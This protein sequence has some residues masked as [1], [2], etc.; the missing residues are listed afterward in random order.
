MIRCP[1][2]RTE[3]G[4]N[5]FNVATDRAFCRLCNADYRYGELATTVWP[6]KQF[7]VDARPTHVQLVDDGFQ[8]TLVYH[9]ISRLIF[10]FIPFTALWSGL[11][12][13]GLYVYPWLAGKPI[14]REQALFGIPFVIGTIVLLAAML[15][16][17][18]GKTT[19]RLQ[20]PESWVLTGIGPIGR[21][22]S[23]DAGQVESVRIVNSDASQNGKQLTCL[24]LQMRSR[25]AVRFGMFMTDESKRYVAD[26]LARQLT[27]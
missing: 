14:D 19:I 2:C 10:F 13:G 15:Y 20:G 27:S 3:I 4:T 7:D 16:M 11:S 21:R 22:Q 1:Q 9:R 18:F 17:L 12:V 5:D 25:G 8:Q 24:E 26:Y 6:D 23:F